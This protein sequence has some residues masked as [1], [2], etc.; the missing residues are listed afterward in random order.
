MTRPLRSPVGT[1]SAVYA[2]YLQSVP[3]SSHMSALWSA[4]IGRGRVGGRP[5]GDTII[6]KAIGKV[7]DSREKGRDFCVNRIH[8]RSTSLFPLTFLSFNPSFV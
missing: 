6:V 4:W 8:Y 5:S 7:V 1:S 2:V 3:L